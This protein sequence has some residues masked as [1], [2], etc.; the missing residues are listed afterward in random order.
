M[1]VT[2]FPTVKQLI[3]NDDNCWS[4]WG[5]SMTS[6]GRH[7]VSNHRQPD[8]LFYSLLAGYL[9]RNIKATHHHT[10]EPIRLPWDKHK[11]PLL[12]FTWKMFISTD[13]TNFYWRAF[14]MR[15]G[16]EQLVFTTPT[17][18]KQ[19]LFYSK[20]HFSL[21]VRAKQR[22]HIMWFHKHKIELKYV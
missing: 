4:Q 15:F 19:E 2:I 20:S 16:V 13:L 6:H 7:C 5:T 12:L 9:K 3:S 11:T 21:Q 17:L 18:W 8:C 22:R 10:G 1:V 14:E